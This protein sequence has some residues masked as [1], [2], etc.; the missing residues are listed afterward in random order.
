ML[1]QPG[2]V[3]N[4]KSMTMEI[5]SS[6]LNISSNFNK[7]KLLQMVN[8]LSLLQNTSKV[9]NLKKKLVVKGPVA[10]M[11]TN[12]NAFEINIQ[13]RKQ[14]LLIL[15][16]LFYIIIE[17]YMIGTSRRQSAYFKPYRPNV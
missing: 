7:T 12:M 16:F 14:P 15:Y 5:E 9:T 8:F 3:N 2:L 13:K 1:M 6:G 10:L 17:R 4:Y 11:V